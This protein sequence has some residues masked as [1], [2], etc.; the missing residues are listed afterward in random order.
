MTTANDPKKAGP[1]RL[2]ETSLSMDVRT[3]IDGTVKRTIRA[4][5]GGEVFTTRPIWE[6]AA[7]TME[8]PPFAEALRVAL[9]ASYA[10]MGLVSDYARKLRG[11]GVSWSEIF[12]LLGLEDIE[13]RAKHEAAYEFI[14]GPDTREFRFD[15]RYVYWACGSCTQ[16]VRDRGPYN[17][18]PADNETGHA[19]DCARHQAEIDAYMSHYEDE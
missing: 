7:S 11:D 3:A 19:E 18:H 12:P 1:T 13:G 14:L 5:L 4:Q 6:G 15:E 2:D 16:G 8:V 9:I 10:A 17:G